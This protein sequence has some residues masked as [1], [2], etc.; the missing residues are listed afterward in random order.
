[1]QVDGH[2]DNL[3]ITNI[4]RFS[5]NDGPGIRTT[6]FFK[7]CSIHCP[8]CANPENIRF[9]KESYIKGGESGQYGQWM[10]CDHLYAQVMRDKAFYVDDGGVTYSGGESLLQIERLV[11]LLKRLS[12]EGISQCVESSLF[13]DREAMKI[14]LRYI[15]CFYVDIK[16]LDEAVCR[17]RLGGNL[18]VYRQNLSMLAASDRPYIFRLPLIEPYTTHDGNIRQ[19]IDLLQEYRPKKVEMIKGHN[20]GASKYRSLGRKVPIVPDISTEFM[21]EYKQKIER[22]GIPA[23]ICRV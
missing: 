11:P 17:H 7:G 10:D 23:E 16:I 22:L 9:E 6:V 15:N 13:V 5:V 14:A 20:L 19:V 2:V 4:Q 21:E 8:W 12:M 3:L 18:S 1:M